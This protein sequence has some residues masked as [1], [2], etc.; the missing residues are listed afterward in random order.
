MDLAVVLPQG[1]SSSTV[2]SRI[3]IWNVGFCGGTKTGEPRKNARRREE[4]QQQT[5]ATVMGGERSHHC[6]I[7]APC[8]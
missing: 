6:A 5:R 4:N 8:Q 1:G 2:S 3:G 7:P